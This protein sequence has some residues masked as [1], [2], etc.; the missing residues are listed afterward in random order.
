MYCFNWPLVGCLQR[1]DTPFQYCR[2]PGVNN[3]FP[4]RAGLKNGN[5]VK[6]FPESPGI[7]R[8][9]GNGMK[10]IGETDR[11]YHINGDVADGRWG[12][13]CP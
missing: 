8:P 3:L 6:G 4:D 13:I 11:H 2:S 10:N 7:P 9:F 1:E 12:D 5:A